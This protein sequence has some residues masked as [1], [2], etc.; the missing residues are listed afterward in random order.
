M[1]IVIIYFVGDISFP[2]L[3]ELSI[4]SFF[5][6]AKVRRKYYRLFKQMLHSC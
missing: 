1:F 5:S 3:R 4:F 2:Y 6:A